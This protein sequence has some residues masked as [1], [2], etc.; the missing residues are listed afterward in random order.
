MTEDRRGRVA[1]LYPGN[2]EARQSATPDNNRF[3]QLFRALANL[4][5]DVSPAVYHD[6]F[7]EEVRRQLMQVDAVLV[8]M[9]P[10]EDGHD[11]SILDSMLRAV[12]ATGVFVSTH[13]D[14]ILKMGTKEVVYRTRDIGWGCDTH[15]YCDIEQI[16]QELPARLAAGQPRVL[17]QYRGN[18]GIGVWKVELAMSASV[19]NDRNGGG[20]LPQ[21]E[22][23][24]RVRHAQRGSIEEEIA[25]G[26]FLTRCEQYFAGH[27]KM[28][29]QAYQPRLTEGMVRCYLVHD[30]VAGFGH[31][32]INALY[33]A[34]AGAPPDQAPQPG[35]R[36]Y[37]PP[38]MPAFESLKRELEQQWVPAMQRLLDIDTGSLPVLW[39]ADFLLGPKTESGEDTHVLCEINVSSVAPFPESAVPYVAE[40]TIAQTEAA[41]RRRQ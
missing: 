2:R 1:I 5:V 23:L 17:K 3:S 37:H 41:R 39:D 20:A 28:I 12:A 9:N 10:I 29:D 4:G 15:L 19:D 21:P 27:G 18:G 33:P 36:L 26:E 22:T 6:E 34:P 40:A 24:I 35:P 32:A 38:T 25:L 16:R 31:Q 30:R 8:W 13:P 14:V 11:R 7:C